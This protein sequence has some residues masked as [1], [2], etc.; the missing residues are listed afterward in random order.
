MACTSL[1]LIASQVSAQD[2]IVEKVVSACE[3]DI[4]QFCSRVTPGDGR[5]LMCLEEYAA[6]V[7]DTCKRAVQDTVGE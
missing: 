4:N 7:S 1:L 5:I 3:A 2:A 6:E